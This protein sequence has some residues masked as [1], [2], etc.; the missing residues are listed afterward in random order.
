M[1]LGNTLLPRQVRI[2]WEPTTGFAYT[3]KALK[4]AEQ[5]IEGHGMGEHQ[6]SMAG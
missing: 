4:P 2:H 5:H 6:T 1:S 3:D